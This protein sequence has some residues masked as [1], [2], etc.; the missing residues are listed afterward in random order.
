MWGILLYFR[1]YAPSR[2]YGG[3]HLLAQVSLL[4]NVK[5]LSKFAQNTSEL[6]DELS[7]FALVALKNV[8][9]SPYSPLYLLNM[10]NAILMNK[11]NKNR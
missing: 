1:T 10:A 7:G 8:Y 9:L 3:F 2:N 6:L 5:F 11:N 4:K